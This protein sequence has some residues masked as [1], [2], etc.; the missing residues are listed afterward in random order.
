MGL[1]PAPVRAV[2]DPLACPFCD[3]HAAQRVGQWGGQMITSQWRCK[4]CGSYFE[5]VREEFDYEIPV[6]PQIRP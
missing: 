2:T 3:T 4:A 6:D 1:R 5:A